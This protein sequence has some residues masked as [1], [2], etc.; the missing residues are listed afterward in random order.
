MPLDRLT[1]VVGRV[2]KLVLIDIQDHGLRTSRRPTP[3]V[4]W[5]DVD[6]TAHVGAYRNPL[7][8]LKD[9][10]LPG[11]GRL[12]RQ[13]ENRVALVGGHEVDL[14]NVFVDQARAAA[15]GLSSLVALIRGSPPAST[16]WAA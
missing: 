13:V 7:D 5:H 4:A 1:S 14:P 10:Q 6:P 16:C 2:G 15:R 8:E 3:A 9:N 12:G 11:M